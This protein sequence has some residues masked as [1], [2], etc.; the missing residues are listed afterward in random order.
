MGD[1]RSPESFLLQG[2]ESL[3]DYAIFVLD[4]EGVVMSWNKGAEST[5]GYAANEV[6]G[7]DCSM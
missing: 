3:E 7:K 1:L 6:I 4:Q 5:M 2:I